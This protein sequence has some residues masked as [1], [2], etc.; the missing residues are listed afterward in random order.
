MWNM[1]VE[2]EVDIHG[3]VKKNQWSDKFFELTRQL[4]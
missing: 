2:I 1:K 4:F 3:V